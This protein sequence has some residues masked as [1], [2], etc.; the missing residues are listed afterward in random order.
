MN[1]FRDILRKHGLKLWLAN[2]LGTLLTFAIMFVVSIIGFFLIAATFFA[3]FFQ[4]FSPIWKNNTL[5]DQSQVNQTLHSLAN[6]L[7][8]YI[9]PA[10]LC[11]VILMIVCMF[12]FAFSTAGMYGSS[13]EAIRNDRSKLATYFTIGYQNLLRIFVLFLLIFVV[14]IPF[15]ILVV[16]ISILLLSIASNPFATF[17]IILLLAAV[18]LALYFLFMSMTMNAPII[19]IAEKV[20]PWKSLILSFRLLKRETSRVMLTALQVLLISFSFAII[21]MSWH[22]PNLISFIDPFII[23]PIVTFIISILDMV[24]LPIL[25]PLSMMVMGLFMTQRYFK[26]LRHTIIPNHHLANDTT[27]FVVKTDETTTDEHIDDQDSDQKK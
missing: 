11:F 17:L 10:I 27:S 4:T 15:I 6:E 22:I 25:T 3:E 12:I 5:N 16:I 2:F 19:L 7:S 21:S 14:S 23:G 9:L 24:L 18:L 1:R 8:G 26:Y 20:S 13:I